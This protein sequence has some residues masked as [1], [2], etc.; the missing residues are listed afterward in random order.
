MSN[1]VTPGMS[2]ADPVPQVVNWSTQMDSM[3][4]KSDRQGKQLVGRELGRT[5]EE[6]REGRGGK[7]EQNTLC[8]NSQRMKN[9]TTPTTTKTQSNKQK[10]DKKGAW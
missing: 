8:G 9:F 6:L 7:Y 2:G 4:S 10:Q 3:S 1:A 5:W